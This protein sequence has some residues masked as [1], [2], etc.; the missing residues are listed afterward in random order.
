[1]HESNLISILQIHLSLHPLY[2]YSPLLA[3]GAMT[4]H[5]THFSS[6][7]AVIGYY[8]HMPFS[9]QCHPLSSRS[10]AVSI[11]NCFTLIGFICVQHFLCVKC[12]CAPRQ[13]TF[14]TAHFYA[15]DSRALV[16]LNFGT[17]ATFINCF[18][19][20]LQFYGGIYMKLT[21]V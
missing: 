15:I 17:I 7:L 4:F 8:T 9:Q 6:I 10:P 19:T 2:T 14:A 13:F 1:M 18:A 20:F 5:P 16:I 11:N 21:V 12:L 3:T